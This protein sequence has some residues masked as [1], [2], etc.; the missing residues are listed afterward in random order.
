MSAAVIK[1]LKVLM[2]IVS[3][4]VKLDEETRNK[5]IIMVSA[6][7]LFLMFIPVL[8]ISYVSKHPLKVLETTLTKS[9]LKFVQGIKDTFSDDTEIQIDYDD[10][11]PMGEKNLKKLIDEGK[12]YIGMPYVWGG[13]S[14]STGF[15]CSGFVCYV[16]TNSGVKDMPRT[17][18]QGIYDNYTNKIPNEEAKAGDIVFFTKTYSTTK[19]ITHVGIYLGSNYMLHCGDPIGYAK[20]DLPYWAEHFHSFGRVR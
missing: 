17:T 20:L 18:A 7:L 1:A 19:T 12:Q 4:L 8:F 16:Y 3:Y 6:S 11:A 14:P 5:I 13:S 2:K 9:A 15:D 10:I